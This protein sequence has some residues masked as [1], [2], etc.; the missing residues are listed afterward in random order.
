MTQQDN[1]D[2]LLELARAGLAPSQPDQSRVLAALEQRLGLPPASAPVEPTQPTLR[3]ADPQPSAAETASVAAATVATS[4]LTRTALR[5]ARIAAITLTGAAAVALLVQLRRAEPPSAAVPPST[6]EAPSAQAA[7]A[8]D[9]ALAPA[10]AGDVVEAERPTE[11]EETDKPAPKP[12]PRKK[13]RAAN[14]TERPCRTAQEPSAVAQSAPAPAAPEPEPPTSSLREELTALR[15]AEL[16]L[17]TGKPAQ[18]LEVLDAYARKATTEGKLLEERAAVASMAR[19]QVSPSEARTVLEA[20]LQRYP[21]SA[22]NV[23]IRQSC[24][25]EH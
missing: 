4:R 20:F 19:C 11:A 23:R 16:A 15:G 21:N 1:H 8:P 13:C 5:L 17:R 7:P 6:P 3:S 12:A 2:E 14:G 24:R 10:I 18:A 25:V 22:Y 9:P